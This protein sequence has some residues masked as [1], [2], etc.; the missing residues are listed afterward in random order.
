MKRLIIIAIALSIPIMIWWVERLIAKRRGQKLQGPS[1]LMLAGL[2]L[3]IM[4]I[5][6]GLLLS[7]TQNAP[8]GSK[9]VPAQSI[10][11]KIVSGE[12]K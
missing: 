10:D 2:A 6:V 9:Y 1:V 5:L 7:Q 8:E 3:A 4:I 11:G 12:F